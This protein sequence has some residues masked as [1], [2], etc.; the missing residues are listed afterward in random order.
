MAQ[1]FYVHL[2]DATTHGNN[3]Q[4]LHF[5]GF[6]F[7]QHPNSAD[8]LSV[9]T[10]TLDTF[11]V[12]A[13]VHLRG[14]YA[15]VYW[16]STAN[17]WTLF[18]DPLGTKPLYYA[19]LS[20]G[21]HISNH[22]D[23][24][25]E[26]IR[27][28]QPLSLSALG[29]YQLLSYGFVLESDTIFNPIKRLPIGHTATI[30]TL[31]NDQKIA[32][33]V[34]L[35]L[36]KCYSLP[37]IGSTLSLDDAAAQVDILFRAAIKK[38]FERDASKKNTSLV[39]LSGGLDSRMTSWVAHEMGYTDQLN[40][41]FAQQNSLDH[42]IAQKIGRDLN[43]KWHFMP[44]DGGDM[45]RDLDEVTQHTGG[46]VV[47]YGQAHTRRILQEIVEKNTTS[48]LGML[49]TGM[50]GDV[51]IGSYLQT[52]NNPT[53]FS[54]LSGASS[55]RFS[56]QLV[57]HGFKPNYENLEH[58]K[59]ML[60]GLYGMNMGLM[61][62]YA[63]TESYSPF[64]D[65]DL[66][67]FCL[68]LPVEL[69]AQHKLYIHWITQYYPEASNYIWERT[70]AKITAKSIRIGSKSLPLRTWIWKLSERIQFG[71]PTRN[72]RFMTPLDYW[73]ATETQLHS[74][75]NSY[76]NTYLDLIDER[77]MRE[78]IHDLYTNGNGKEKVQALSVIAA[79]KRYLT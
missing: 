51:V 48:S 29:F 57:D 64:Y 24:L 62:V 50:L 55:L 61:S 26:K 54:A 25:A 37:A 12:H 13:P 45:L 77:E 9:V 6:V 58:H 44:L 63:V 1:S 67:N 15:G 52:S 22:Y 46:N 18:S 47:Y 59:I 33:R 31:T 19:H 76:F 30:A 8:E 74:F 14:S 73:F 3:L 11:G 27:A 72:P 79:A 34:T 66:F 21:W 23:L 68:Q 56:N 69:R 35:K 75:L 28:V 71:Q 70:R 40:L 32:P 10:N 65:Y 2:S 41:C 5:S 38:A 7:T 20:N 53:H 49:H 4:R 36:H 39:S 60:R 42:T 17:Q 16:S 78:H 43:H